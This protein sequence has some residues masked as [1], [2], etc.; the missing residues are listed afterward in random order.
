VSN[1]LSAAGRLVGVLNK[2]MPSLPGLCLFYLLSSAAECSSSRLR[3]FID[4]IRA[5]EPPAD[6]EIT[7]Q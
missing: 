4:V 1:C 3:A 6:D 7:D 5:I 2:W